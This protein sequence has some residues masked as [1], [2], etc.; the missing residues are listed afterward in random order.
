R[1]GSAF[2]PV[3]LHFGFLERD[4]RLVSGSDVVVPQDGGR[5]NWWTQLAWSGREYGI[6][7]SSLDGDGGV[8]FSRISAEGQLVPSSQR[9]VTDSVRV[10]TG[11]LDLHPGLAW[12]PQDSEW[13]VSWERNTEVMFARLDPQ[14]GSLGGPTKLGNGRYGITGNSP[15]IWAGTGY[16]TVWKDDDGVRLV[17]LDHHGKVL[18]SA[19]LAD[20]GVSIGQPTL[21]F[22]GSDYG[23]VWSEYTPTTAEAHFARVRTGPRSV[24][25]SDIVISGPGWANAPTIGWGGSAYLVAYDAQPDGGQSRIAVVQVGPGG[26]VS[27]ARE[28][29]CSPGYDSSA[30]LVWNG[31][32]F[33][34]TYSA[35]T[36]GPYAL[37]G[38]ILFVQEQ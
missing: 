27:S 4:G 19:V 34:I 32:V 37:D 21:A 5:I 7:S 20:A 2:N 13:G 23:V 30:N 11:A 1:P 25:G 9:R 29:T 35:E 12:N 3:E 33:S 31:S 22:S 24:A 14:G 15:L 17:E 10:T 8:S 38:R 6:V 16:A 36:R 18:G 28:L 26:A